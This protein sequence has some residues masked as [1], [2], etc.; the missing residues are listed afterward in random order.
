MKNN[1]AV[2]ENKLTSPFT[3]SVSSAGGLELVI[4]IEASTI[5]LFFNSSVVPDLILGAREGEKCI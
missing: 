2:E 4:D 1:P 3:G 5:S